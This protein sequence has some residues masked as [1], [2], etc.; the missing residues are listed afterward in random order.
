MWRDPIVDE[1]RTIRNAYA[2]SFGYDLNAIC[3]AL[4][5]RERLKAAERLYRFHRKY[6]I[7]R[8]ERAAKRAR[9]WPNT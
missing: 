3:H 7:V 9:E 4:K 1:V 5:E 2:K 6:Q 8:E